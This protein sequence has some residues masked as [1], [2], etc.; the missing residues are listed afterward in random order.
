MGAARGTTKGPA[1]T[2]VVA[3][4]RA[5]LQ[6]RFYSAAAACAD[7]GARVQARLTAT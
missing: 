2:C 4:V 1:V 6:A 3:M 7:L 5:I